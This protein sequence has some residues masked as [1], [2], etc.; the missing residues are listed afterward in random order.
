MSPCR[1]VSNFEL[2]QA[3]KEVTKSLRTSGATHNSH[4][5]PRSAL[6]YLAS[7]AEFITQR[8][9]MDSDNSFRSRDGGISSSSSSTSSSLNSATSTAT[10]ATTSE[11]SIRG[12]S[13]NDRPYNIRADKRNTLQNFFSRSTSKN[14]EPPLNR[15]QKKVIRFCQ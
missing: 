2:I 6:P 7:L 15:S 5:S 11:D 8:S 3:R 4:H 13:G 9:T 10:I 14:V 1:R 12:E